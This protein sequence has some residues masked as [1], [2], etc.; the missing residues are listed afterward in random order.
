[1]TATS[2]FSVGQG[3]IG[4]SGEDPLWNLQLQSPDEVASR[5]SL[6]Y[7]CTHYPAGCIPKSLLRRAGTI[8]TPPSL[9]PRESTSAP[10][11]VG[12]F[13]ARTMRYSAVLWLTGALPVNAASTLMPTSLFRLALALT[14]SSPGPFCAPR[15][16]PFLSCAIPTSFP[17][18]CLLSSGPHPT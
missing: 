9:L 17:S 6:S 13:P 1:M 15:H 5:R 12:W 10:S 8:V 7:A 2:P 18:Q 11:S 16:P 14:L 3:P 4:L